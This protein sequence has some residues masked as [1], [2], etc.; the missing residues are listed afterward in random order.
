MN[1]ME[2]CLGG[3]WVCARNR[4]WRFPRKFMSWILGGQCSG[5]SEW[6]FPDGV[7]IGNLDEPVVGKWKGKELGA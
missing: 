6:N 3:N 1:M 2:I 5:V 7:Q 4:P